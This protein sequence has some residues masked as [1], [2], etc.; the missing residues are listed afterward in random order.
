[1]IIEVII[2]NV[3]HVSVIYK[4]WYYLYRY[5]SDGVEFTDEIKQLAKQW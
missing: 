5:T 4:F 3:H 1:M 2:Q